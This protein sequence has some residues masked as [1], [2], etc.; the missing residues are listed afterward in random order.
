MSTMT[1]VVNDG[2]YTDYAI[3]WSLV[4][5]IYAEMGAI[6]TISAGEMQ[7]NVC[8]FRASI[9]LLCLQIFTIM[10][11]ENWIKFNT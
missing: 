11:L 8:D 7:K 1:T 3:C 4:A 6:V 9:A 5:E 2:D 10:I